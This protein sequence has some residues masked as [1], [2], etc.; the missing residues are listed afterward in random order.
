MKIS[1]S[2][3][4]IA[5]SVALT[6]CLELKT[7]NSSK[8]LPEETLTSE[9]PPVPFNVE[10]QVNRQT[11]LGWNLVSFPITETTDLETF[12]TN[13]SL[14][15]VHSVWKWDASSSSWAVYPDTANYDVLVSIAPNEGYWVRASEAFELTGAGVT[16]NTYA[17]VEGWNQ[18]G[19]SHSGTA[20][21]LDSFFSDGEFWGTTCLSDTAVMSV[22][23]WENNVWKIHFPGDDA[24][25]HP[26]LD[27]FNITNN[28]SF[29]A[30][31]Q[32][33]P[34]MGVWLQA[35]QGNGSNDNCLQVIDLGTATTFTVPENGI[36]YLLHVY[37]DASPN[38]VGVAS[39]TDPNSTNIFNSISGI[40]DRFTYKS[41][42]GNLLN[43]L[44]PELK[45][46]PGQWSFTAYEGSSQANNYKLALRTGTT[47]TPLLDIQPFLTGTNY[48]ITDLKLALDKAEQIY[49]NA[50]IQ[51]H[52]RNTLVVADTSLAK[53]STNF[54]DTTTQQLLALGSPSVVNLYFIE[55]FTG[56]AAGTLGVSAGIPGSMGIAGKYNGVLNSIEA[57][58]TDGTVQSVLLGET[59]A[60]EMG[61]WLGLYHPS[62]S[63]GITFDPLSSTPECPISQ[64]STENGGDG[65]GKVS[66]SECADFGGDNLMFWL[67]DPNI[68]QE[69]L[70]EGQKHIII[71][72]PILK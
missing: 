55:D 11:Q 68:V 54:E 24:S 49:E 53:V 6:S 23:A 46:T 14:E 51:V 41:T 30:L 19:Y 9:A 72:S 28:T 20:K 2:L 59:L 32:I 39:L 18:I 37:G 69:T 70:S 71:N 47:N 44:V 26:R 3:I 16:Q 38:A 61:H 1:Y 8:A 34:G 56:D 64:D 42:Y 43:P 7:N 62:E 50:G 52:F 29:E 13:E 31:T 67:G 45:A 33:Q 25:N 63:D 5:L 40:E 35:A 4:L 15:E 12:I 17:F 21:S 36:S 22:W 66:P 58:K 48:S 10:N 60:H 57:H 27:A 65:N